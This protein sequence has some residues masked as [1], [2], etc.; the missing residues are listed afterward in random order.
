MKT[1]DDL[2]AR[3]EALRRDVA[4]MEPQTAWTQAAGCNLAGAADNLRWHGEAAAKAL[5]N[6][7]ARP[8]RAG[9]DGAQA[10]GIRAQ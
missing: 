10:G 2:L 6:H 7:A 8:P 1:N 4:A 3:V 5:Q 9:A